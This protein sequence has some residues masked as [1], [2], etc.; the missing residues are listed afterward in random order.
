MRREAVA[1]LE[2]LH[3]VVSRVQS[4]VTDLQTVAYELATGQP[5]DPGPREEYLSLSQ[6]CGRVPYKPQTIRNL[7][8]QGELREGE[9]FLQRRRHGRIVFIWSRMQA[10]LTARKQSSNEP[11][12]FIPHHA[13]SRKGR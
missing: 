13:R 5:V 8:V 3:A 6:M 11:Q 12:A 7:I 10:W 9:H 4:A 1:P 2:R